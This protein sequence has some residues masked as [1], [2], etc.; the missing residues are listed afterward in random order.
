[1]HSLQRA[2]FAVVHKRVQDPEHLLAALSDREWDVVISDHIMPTFSGPSALALVRQVDRDIPFIVVSG[3]VGEESAVETMR[4]GAHDYVL[5]HNLARLPAAIERELRDAQERRARKSAEAKIHRMA[6]YDQLT[7]L[8][9]RAS[10]RE[11]GE[12]VLREQAQETGPTAVLLLKIDNLK[13]INHTLG[14]SIG[15]QLIVETSERLRASGRSHEVL[16]MARVGTA[17]LAAIA[18]ETRSLL[19]THH[20]RHRARGECLRWTRACA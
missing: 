16:T 1:V 11:R 19:A 7:G 9:N 6:Y 18:T 2:G 8:P 14:H 12:R 10:L 4:A 13:E 5:K 15:E 17:E 3:S 20:R